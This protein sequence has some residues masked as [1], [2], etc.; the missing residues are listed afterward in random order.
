MSATRKAPLKTITQP[1]Q[2]ATLAA[3]LSGVGL[4][5][6]DT[7]SNSLHAYRE[8][9]CLLQFSTA[10]DDYILDPLSLEDLSSLR[11]IFADDRIEKIF[12]AAEYD[13]IGLQRDFC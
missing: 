2:L 5:A 11:A 10:S 4:L 3:E 8:R 13:L 9:V 7:E 1:D 6:V 12:H